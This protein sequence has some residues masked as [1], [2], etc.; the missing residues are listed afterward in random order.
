MVHGNRAR[1]A[2]SYPDQWGQIGSLPPQ[3]AGDPVTAPRSPEQ[4][5][6][7]SVCPCV[8]AGV[9]VPVDGQDLVSLVPVLIA[10]PRQEEGFMLG[11]NLSQTVFVLADVYLN[12]LA[13]LDS[14][15]GDSTV[16]LLDPLHKLKVVHIDQDFELGG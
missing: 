13:G 3:V 5:E 8:G 11:H 4:V 10:L 12:T 2:L 15:L 6:S 1:P 9:G 7:L 14:M 16:F